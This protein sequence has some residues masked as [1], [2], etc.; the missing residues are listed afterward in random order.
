MALA[1]ACVHLL[2]YGSGQ[3]ETLLDDKR[4]DFVAPRMKLWLHGRMIELSKV[5]S[6]PQYGGN[7]VPRDWE[8]IRVDAA[9]AA[10]EVIAQHVASFDVHADGGIVY[11]NGFDIFKLESGTRCGVAR[12]Q[13]VA[14]LSVI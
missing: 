6:D 3:L 2:D 10:P 7:L 5:K 9:G 13:Q 11:T 8:L 1:H 12:Q 4:H 14:G